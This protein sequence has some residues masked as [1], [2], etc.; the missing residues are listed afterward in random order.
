MK[1]SII[2]YINWR[3]IAHQLDKRIVPRT[4][5]QSEWTKCYVYVSQRRCFKCRSN[6][7]LLKVKRKWAYGAGDSV[8]SSMIHEYSGSNWDIKRLHHSRHRNAT[9]DIRLSYC[10]LTCTPAGKTIFVITQSH[11]R[12]HPREKS[13]SRLQERVITTWC[14]LVRTFKNKIW[15]NL[16]CLVANTSNRVSPVQ[17]SDDFRSYLHS[18]PKKTAV[19]IVQSISWI[20]TCKSP[21]IIR[22]NE[23]KSKYGIT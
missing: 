4:R 11:R 13:S 6:D 5:S 23:S 12:E 8:A 22:T 1:E 9:T 7:I 15:A 10:F 14:T 18:L 3:L 19:G 2:V 16:V 20:E 21:A 17:N